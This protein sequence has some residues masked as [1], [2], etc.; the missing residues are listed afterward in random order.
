MSS[1]AHKDGTDESHKTSQLLFHTLAPLKLRSWHAVYRDLKTHIPLRWR[2]GH[3][4]L[5]WAGH[6]EIRGTLPDWWL[7]I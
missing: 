5:P 2:R 4:G 6:G 1:R 3:L 7:N